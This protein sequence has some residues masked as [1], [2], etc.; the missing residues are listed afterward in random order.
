MDQ[1][2]AMLLAGGQG[3]RLNILA[4][5]RAKPAVPFGG[6]YRIIDFT[7]SNIMHSGIENVG[8]LTQYR[9]SSLM[10]H[11]GPGEA[12]DLV[13]RRRG[14]KILPP[15]TGTTGADWYKGTADAIFQNI[16]YI[17]DHNPDLVL[18][19]SG[20]HIYKMDYIPMIEL[21][22]ANR[23]DLTIA[24]MEVPLEEASRFG[25]IFIDTD[26]RI[27]G[28]EEKPPKPR[29]NLVS[30][31]IYVF[32]TEALYKTLIQDAKRNT[33]HDFGK[34]IIPGMLGTYKLYAYRFKGYWRDVGTI[35]SY[36]DANMDL[37]DSYSGLD[38]SAWKV[39]TNME[40]RNMGDRPPTKLLANGKAI[41]SLITQGCLI[42][43]S[44]ENSILS[45]GVI[46]RED[47]QI[48][49]S[50]VMHNSIIGEGAILDKVIVDKDV[51]VGA[52]S[53][54]G[55]GD[56]N[57][58]NQMFP[59]HLNTGITVVGKGAVL[60]G[61]IRLERNCIIYPRVSPAQFT[62]PLVQSGSTILYRD[63]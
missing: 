39:R 19:L 50:V 53:I 47:A 13:G 30:L 10:D 58:P 52:R 17:K 63:E 7:L 40:D 32:N 49:N 56:D 14:I 59:N 51:K 3:S 45:P 48:R 37:L 62:T 28:F 35:Q 43:G 21:H 16:Q 31:G 36:L 44:I 38:I 15:Y 20:D 23:A 46:V 41:N 9:P 29:S 22:K 24:V 60:P 6:M 57:T 54:L 2:I 33:S 26:N 5:E 11:I 27:T 61:S 8:V 55:Y 42:K 25:T 4:S 18:I 12:W 34:D 1:I